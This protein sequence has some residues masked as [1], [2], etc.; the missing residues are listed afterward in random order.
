MQAF[1]PAFHAAHQATIITRNIK[2][3][4]RGAGLAPFNPE[5]VISKLDVQL[6][7]PTP[8]EEDTSQAQPWTPKTPRTVI[9]AD[10]HSDYLQRR[11]RRHHSSSPES[12]LE[13]LQSLTK[14]VMKN[15]HRIA[16]LEAENQ[17]LR[18]E[19]TTNSRRKRKKNTHLYDNGKMNIGIGQSQIDQMDVDMQVAAESS[20]S[21]GR[22]RS[23]GP[24][25]RRCGTCGKTG[26]NA[27]TCQEVIEVTENEDSD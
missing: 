27:R 17:E 9:E 5:H 21:C 25:V 3:G 22:G 7:T 26:H 15:M 19:N 10:S 24:G 4:F 23:V 12:I 2:G 16:V 14:S 20:R 18:E 13:A 8:P 6:R 11:I 1:F